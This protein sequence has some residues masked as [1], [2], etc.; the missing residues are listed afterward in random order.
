MKI[1]YIGHSGFLLEWK[2]CYWLFDYC[3]GTIPQMNP[4]KRIFVFVSHKHEDHFNPTVFDLYHKYPDV[5]Y[6]L[7]SDIDPSQAELPVTASVL[8]V[9]PERQYELHDNDHKAICLG[10]LK[11]TDCGVAFLLEYLGKTVYHAGDLNLWV[12]KE[13]TK[14]YNTEMTVMFNEQMRAL[15]DLAIDIAFAPL[16]P[17]QE[18]HYYMGLEGL[19]NT[20]K[21]RYVFPMHFGMEFSVIDRYKRERANLRQVQIMDINRAGQDWEIDL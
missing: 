21:I 6:V 11:S 10:T 16:D 12:W 20:A 3:T 18:E 15:E 9:E 1:T 2:T 19:L 4:A 14:R 8:F 17:R 5:Q 13:E 7:S